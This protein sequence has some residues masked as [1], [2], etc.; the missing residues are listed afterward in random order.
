MTLDSQSLNLNARQILLKRLSTTQALEYTGPLG[1]V[2][3]D[4]SLKL[5]RVQDGVTPGGTIVATNVNISNLQAQINSLKSNFD[6]VA[7][8]SITEVL[9]NVNALL[10]RNTETQLV[11][12][13]FYANLTSSGDLVLDGHFLPKSHIAKDLGSPTRAWRDLYLSNSTAYFGNAALTITNNGLTLVSGGR[14]LPYIGNIR[15]PDGSTQ[16]T[17][18]NQS[19]LANIYALLT[20]NIAANLTAIHADVTN[21]ISYFGQIIEAETNDIRANLSSL[22]KTWTAPHT[23]NVWST[24]EYHSG[25][26]VTNIGF[27][28]GLE[29]QLTTGRSAAEMSEYDSSDNTVSVIRVNRS[30]FPDLNKLITGFESETLINANVLIDIN[31]VGATSI[32]KDGDFFVITLAESIPAFANSTPFTLTYDTTSTGIPVAWFDVNNAATGAANFRG[33]V[34]D[35]HALSEDSGTLVGTINM[36]NNNGGTFVTHSESGSGVPTLYNNILWGRFG[37]DGNKLYYYRTDGI[38]SAISIHWVAKLFYGADYL[39]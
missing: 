5:L 1:E 27:G 33:A 22:S 36:S 17:A 2:I 15:F 38:E 32:D 25:V 31:T 20:P 8:D 34:I 14:T 9:A 28:T 13:G 19:T 10:D 23:G 35:Y 3:I 26:R 30:Q 6:P 39:E 11:N 29:K 16:T 24:L 7:I 4:T 21:A 18:V 12:S 37:S